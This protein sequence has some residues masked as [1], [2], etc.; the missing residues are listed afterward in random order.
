MT[1]SPDHY[2]NRLAEWLDWLFSWIY[3]RLKKP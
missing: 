3:N 2:A 1:M